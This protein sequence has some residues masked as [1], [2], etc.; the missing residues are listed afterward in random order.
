MTTAHNLF[1][2]II[3][4]ILKK[5][6]DRT[7]N[8]QMHKFRNIYIS[9]NSKKSDDETEEEPKICL[10]QHTQNL[11]KRIIIMYRELYPNSAKHMH[12]LRLISKLGKVLNDSLEH[13]KLEKKQRKENWAKLLQ[14]ERVL[15]EKLGTERIDFISHDPPTVQ[16]I[17]HLKV[18]IRKQEKEK[19]CLENEFEVIRRYI[20]LNLDAS[21]KSLKKS[22]LPPLV[23]LMRYNPEKFVLSKGNMS[24]IIEFRD[25]LEKHIEEIR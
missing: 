2:A 16:Q 7:L 1:S 19:K 8:V 14:K 22:D 23:Q 11:M 6:V 4:Y 18:Y 15:R 21:F 3:L 17:E 10:P 9:S 25:M 13:L 20:I 12:H 24:K 5:M